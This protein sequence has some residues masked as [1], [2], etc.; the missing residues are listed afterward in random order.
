MEVRLRLELEGEAEAPVVGH[1][2][3]ALRGSLF[4]SVLPV[5]V[6]DVGPFGV[7]FPPGPSSPP[8]NEEAT[9]NPASPLSIARAWAE[10]PPPCCC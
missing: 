9:P 5:G 10:K 8:T 7:E 3:E 4:G 6:R 2:V 1:V